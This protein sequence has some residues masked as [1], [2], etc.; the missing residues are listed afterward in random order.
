MWG[1][2]MGTLNVYAKKGS[3]LGGALWTKRGALN[4]K[5]YQAEIMYDSTATYRVCETNYV[6]LYM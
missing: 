5:W 4:D 2:D 6:M 3:E 1:A